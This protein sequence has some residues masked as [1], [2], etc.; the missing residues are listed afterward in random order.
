MKNRSAWLGCVV[1]ASVLVLNACRESAPQHTDFTVGNTPAR[2]TAGPG[3]AD[4]LAPAVIAARRTFDN[5]LKEFTGTDRAGQI[6]KINRMASNYRLHI[7]FNTYRALDLA[8][9]YSRLTGDAFDITLGP[10]RDLWGFNGNAHEDVPTD[11]EIA[12]IRNIT[13]SAHFQLSEQ[14]AISILTPGTRITPGLLTYAYGVDLATL[15]LRQRELAPMLITW[16]DFSR[17]LAAEHP[18]I[19]GR[20]AILDPFSERTNALGSIDLAPAAALATAN[21]Y[22]ESVTIGGHRYGGILNPLTGRPADGAAFVAVRGPTCTMAH[23][24]AQA[25]IVLGRENGE[26]ILDQFPECAVLLVPDKQPLE[27]W[28]TPEWATHFQP[29]SAYTNA[30]HAWVPERQAAHTVEE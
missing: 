14:G 24:L 1:A 9:Y 11:E 22:K 15:E 26:A 21:L 12:A 10:L 13:G 16:G 17:A 20:T 25:L 27:I 18:D 19:D 4:Q 8:D 30:V 5:V 3:H 2:I 6:H 28:V 7:T 23:A 29:N